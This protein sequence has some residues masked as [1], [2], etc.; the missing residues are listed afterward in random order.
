MLVKW[1]SECE[2]WN[3]CLEKLFWIWKLVKFHINKIWYKFHTDLS[4]IRYVWET[5]HTLKIP[6]RKQLRRQ[7]SVNLFSRVIWNRN[8]YEIYTKFCSCKIWRVFKFKIIFL[9]I[10]FKVLSLMIL[11]Q[12]SLCWKIADS[13]KYA[14]FNLRFD[15]LLK[16]NYSS[17]RSDIWCTG[18]TLSPLSVSMQDFIHP[19]LK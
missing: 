13:A 10:W 1:S 5:Y 2:L 15:C 3:K 12:A 14:S 16:K 6:I 17:D 8:L 9:N 19:P 18:T 11:S 4:Q 7:L